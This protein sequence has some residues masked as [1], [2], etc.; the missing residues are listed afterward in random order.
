VA[1]PSCKEERDLFSAHIGL[2]RPN[3]NTNSVWW[4]TTLLSPQ[5]FRQAATIGFNWPPHRERNNSFLSVS[6]AT[7]NV[8]ERQLEEHKPWLPKSVH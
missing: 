8:A 6:S 5:V 1:F 3:P 2:V 4:S 7:S